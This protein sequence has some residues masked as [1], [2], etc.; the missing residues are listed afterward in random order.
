MQ[1]DEFK[2]RP[3]LSDPSAFGE[4]TGKSEPIESVFFEKSTSG[5]W[6]NDLEGCQDDLENWIVQTYQ[7]DV[8]NAEEK[9]KRILSLTQTHISGLELLIPQLIRKIQ[10]RLANSAP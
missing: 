6:R 1:L 2:K 3:V 5:N 7:S 8:V 10:K 9:V 4:L